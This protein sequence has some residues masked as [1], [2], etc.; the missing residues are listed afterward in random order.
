MA[1]IPHKTKFGVRYET[2]GSGFHAPA[3]Y[4]KDERRAEKEEIENATP[5]C[6]ECNDTGE[7]EVIFMGDFAFTDCPS[8][9][10]KLE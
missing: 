8:C 7:V 6:I 4:G 5:N 1:A 2:S 9:K 3:K 10:N